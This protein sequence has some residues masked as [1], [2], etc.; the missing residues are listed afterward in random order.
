VVL[1][2]GAMQAGHLLLEP[3]TAAAEERLVGR[4]FRQMAPIL[5]AALGDDAG[6]VGAAMQALGS[7]PSR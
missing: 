1:G 3:A 6:M 2:G 7:P 4:G 5:P